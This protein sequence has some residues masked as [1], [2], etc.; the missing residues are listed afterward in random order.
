[1]EK[2]ISAEC[3]RLI[4]QPRELSAENKAWRDMRE[5][6]YRVH[7]RWRAQMSYLGVGDLM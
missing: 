7:T 3:L 6:K 1:M 2:C 4:S 5:S